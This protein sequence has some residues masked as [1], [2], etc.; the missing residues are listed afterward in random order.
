MNYLVVG[1][2]MVFYVGWNSELGEVD[3]CFPWHLYGFGTQHSFD[4]ALLVSQWLRDVIICLM[5]DR[6]EIFHQ[7]ILRFLVASCENYVY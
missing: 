6:K 3:V 2:G 4:A 1:L 7:K 5:K